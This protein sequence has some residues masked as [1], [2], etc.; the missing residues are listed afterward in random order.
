M[1]L[2]RL[3]VNTYHFQKEV[4]K[5]AKVKLIHWKA[6]EVEER[7]SILEAAGYQ[8]DSTLEQGAEFFKQL[9][10]DPP[11]AIVIDLA[12]LPSQGR[13]L[14]LMLRK[15]KSSRHIPLVF[16][17]GEPGKVEGVNNLLPD[18]WYTTW[19]QVSAV[20]PRAIAN[21]PA[22]PVVHN[23]TF[24]GYEGKPLV[25]KLG[26]KPGMTVGLMNA[27]GDFEEL[28]IELP[29]GVEINSGCSEE[30]GLSI[31]FLRSRADLENEIAD[32]LQQSHHG[33]IWLA[34][35]KKKSG[36]ATDLTQQV[37]RQTGLENSLVDYKISSID[38][39]WSGLLFRYRE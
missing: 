32:I 4:I 39:T 1:L 24:T 19:H 17:D 16:V 37:V 13:D 11:S 27:P 22:D 3:E 23:S 14:A 8:V 7:Q 21:P 38:D 9:V 26:I 25:I 31:W 12:R 18:A 10:K 28:L 2:F 30:C 33:P 6:E 5:M 35:K 29:A 34:W 20:L 15:R 36:Q